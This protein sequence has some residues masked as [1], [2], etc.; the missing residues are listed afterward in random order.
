M[1]GRTTP[2]RYTP[3]ASPTAHQDGE[4][5]QKVLSA[6]GLGSRRECE[7]L[8]LAG[9]VEID[10]RPVTTLGT[11]ANPQEQEIRVD[12]EPL[13]RTKLVYY[14]VNK[15]EGV[16]TT[17]ADPSGRPRVIDLVPDRG[18]H[19]FPVGR[20]DMSSEGLILVTNDGELANRLTHP[21]YGVEKTYQV[22]VAGRLE[23]EQLQQLRRGV[24]LAEGF[25]KV[26]HVVIKKQLK[27]STMLEIMLD[28]GKNREVRRILARVGHKVLRLKRIAVGSL[29]LGELPVGTFRPLTHEELDKLRET[30]TNLHGA[31]SKRGPRRFGKRP[32]AKNF[33]SAKPGAQR[34]IPK[35]PEVRGTGSIIGADASPAKPRKPS[36]KAVVKKPRRP[37]QGGR[38]S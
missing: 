24:H 14:M 22:E 8:I 20:L 36:P 29:R 4:R 26:A 32:G 38:R 5:L 3:E 9:R 11:K 33:R 13:P 21:R 10:R 7:E 1:K 2:P 25:A 16:V 23:N 31:R 19:L 28:E 27:K 6:A 15:P 18:G 30:T 17:N 34:S 12:G 37:P 35:K